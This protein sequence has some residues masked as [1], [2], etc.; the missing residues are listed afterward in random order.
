M[1]RNRFLF[2]L[3][4]G[5][6]SACGI[7]AQPSS[8]PTI[9]PTPEGTSKV[10]QWTPD[11]PWGSSKQ[12]VMKKALAMK[13]AFSETVKDEVLFTQSGGKVKLIAGFGHNGKLTNIAEYCQD[14]EMP[15]PWYGWTSNR[16]SFNYF[17][18]RAKGIL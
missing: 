4:A 1:F 10:I 7:A 12:E 11:L 13:F 18:L 3:M 5:I 16:I 6:S 2:Y 8:A 14:P 17:L 15:I 9:Q